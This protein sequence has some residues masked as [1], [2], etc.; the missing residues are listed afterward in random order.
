[1]SPKEEEVSIKLQAP[2]AQGQRLLQSL[3]KAFLSQSG[4]FPIIPA[5]HPPSGCHGVSAPQQHDA[6]RVLHGTYSPSEP[7]LRANPRAGNIQQPQR[8][9]G[10]A[11]SGWGTISAQTQ[12][13]FKLHTK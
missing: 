5:L 9:P 3:R 7:S 10:R 8:A 2:P 13:S 6:F 11:E 1:M 12:P 4:P